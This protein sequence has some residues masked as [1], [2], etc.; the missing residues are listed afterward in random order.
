MDEIQKKPLENQVDGE[1]NQNKP[2]KVEDALIKLAE[3]AL[4]DS[5]KNS[6]QDDKDFDESS[7]QDDKKNDEKTLELAE[8]TSKNVE[9]KKENVD[10]SQEY[11]KNELNLLSAIN[12]LVGRFEGGKY[13][14]RDL[15]KTELLGVDKVIASKNS[16]K[17]TATASVNGAKLEFVV[18]ISEKNGQM[19]AILRLVENVFVEKTLLFVLTTE[20]GRLADVNSPDFLFKVRKKFALRAKDENVGLGSIGDYTAPAIELMGEVSFKKREA[21]ILS[22]NR[23]KL[24]QEYVSAVIGILKTTANGKLV[25]KEFLRE[26]QKN[27]YA[28][29]AF[30]LMIYRQILDNLIIDA[31]KK[32]LLDELQ[33]QKIAETKTIYVEKSREVIAE[34]RK[35]VG[36][37]PVGDARP[38]E[39]V[40]DGGKSGGGKSK[41][42]G[43][44]SGG[45]KSKGGGGKKGGKSKGGDKDKGK[46][47]KGN[48]HHYIRGSMVATGVTSAPKPAPTPA[49]TAP[50]K[51]IIQKEFNSPKQFSNDISEI[52][53][54]TR[55]NDKGFTNEPPKKY[56]IK[57]TIRISIEQSFEK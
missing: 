43:G 47:D 10:L 48:V 9:V 56:E 41:G 52:L 3:D 54:Q 16:E 53:K 22:K 20:I 26:V 38:K 50:K 1:K 44:K 40:K 4:N 34:N 18:D 15:V 37:S 57:K 19:L 29:S 45:G 25:I 31:N 51:A 14:V 7:T 8:D 23:E 27:E 11:D 33:N 32:S 24:D 6:T 21:E 46:D 28:K 36:A 39:A 17:Y 2:E 35:N 12:T 5:D 49:S 55:A 30:R 42:G 13:V